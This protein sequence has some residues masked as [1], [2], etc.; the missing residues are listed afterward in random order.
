[1]T[2]P[3]RMYGNVWKVFVNTEISIVQLQFY[4]IKYQT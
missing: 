2:A 4:N 3:D 1:M